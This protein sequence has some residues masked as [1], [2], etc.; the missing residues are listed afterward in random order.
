VS[1]RAFRAFVQNGPESPAIARCGIRYQPQAIGASEGGRLIGGY[2]F[3]RLVVPFQICITFFVF[4]D[5]FVRAGGIPLSFFLPWR[6]WG[7]HALQW[8]ANHVHCKLQKESRPLLALDFASRI[9]VPA[10]R[11]A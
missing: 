4:S 3:R 10:G 8:R 2:F 1:W 11:S 9:A 6:F 7:P 5:L